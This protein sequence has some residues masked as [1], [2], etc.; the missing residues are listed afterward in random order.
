MALSNF[1]ILAMIFASAFAHGHHGFHEPKCEAPSAEMTAKLDADSQAKI[2]AIWASYDA[3]VN[4]NCSQQ[5]AD[6]GAVFKAYYEAKAAALTGT[7]KEV[8]DQIQ[9]IKASATGDNKWQQWKQIK[10]LI[11]S[12]QDPSVKEALNEVFPWNHG[13]DRQG[14]GMKWHG[15]GDKSSEEAAVPAPSA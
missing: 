1:A 2:A 4:A 11:E 10:D 8:Y 15:K 7:A 5:F 9:A 13:G 3:A 6:T 12:Q 14:K